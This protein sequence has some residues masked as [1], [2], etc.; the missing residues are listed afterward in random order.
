MD[1]M[2]R[3][4][5]HGQGKVCTLPQELIPEGDPG[6]ALGEF[7]AAIRGNRKPETHGA[8]AHPKPGPPP[9]SGGV[10]SW[11]RLR[12]DAEADRLSRLR[13]SARNGL[14]D[15]RGLD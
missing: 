11:W 15:M 5:L 3:V 7:L 12:R 10:L 8:R 2:S 13:G 4:T 9:R 6:C 1:G 14:D